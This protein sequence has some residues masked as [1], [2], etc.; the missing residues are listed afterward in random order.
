M[1]IIAPPVMALWVNSIRV[2]ICGEVGM[3]SPLQSGQW[4]PQPAPE[5]VARTTAPQRMTT[6]F[7]PTTNQAYRRSPSPMPADVDVASGSA[8]PAGGAVWLAMTSCIG[9][10]DC[11]FS[12]KPGR[13]LLVLALSLFPS[14]FFHNSQIP[15]LQLQSL[16]GS[17]RRA[18]GEI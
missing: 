18:G 16:R 5:P 8:N 9:G 14:L 2:A 4:L 12:V 3:T 13:K 7:Q 10:N 6:M 15:G 17:H 11:L 1:V